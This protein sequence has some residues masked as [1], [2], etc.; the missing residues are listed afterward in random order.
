MDQDKDPSGG[1]DYEDSSKLNHEEV[2][3]PKFYL[4]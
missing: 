2:S 3:M 1:G 4:H